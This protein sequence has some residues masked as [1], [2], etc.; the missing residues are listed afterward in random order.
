MAD[1]MFPSSFQYQQSSEN[2]VNCLLWEGLLHNTWSA[3]NFPYFEHFAFY[4]L[5]LRAKIW[6]VLVQQ[7]LISRSCIMSGIK[8]KQRKHFKLN[9]LID[10]NTFTEKNRL[11]LHLSIKFKFVVR[12]TIHFILLTSALEFPPT[13][14]A[15][16]RLSPIVQSRTKSK[17]RE[18]N[19]G[20]STSL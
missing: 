11:F 4:S 9:L 2:Q 8:V 20:T 12:R 1:P 13:C 19:S 17:N 16:L 3:N 6:L 18:G 14:H 5:I 15:V 10:K 7:N